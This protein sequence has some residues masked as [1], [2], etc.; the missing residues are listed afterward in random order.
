MIV[1]PVFF[2]IPLES[3]FL[4]PLMLEDSKQY[5]DDEIENDS[6]KNQNGD[7]ITAK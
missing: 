7:S 4:S 3:A 6:E 2:L 1:F 5:E